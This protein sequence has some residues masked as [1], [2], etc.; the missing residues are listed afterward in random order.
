MVDS[1][2]KKAFSLGQGPQG[3][4]QMKVLVL[5]GNGMLGHVVVKHFADKGHD[6]TFTVREK[7]PEW[8]PLSSPVGVVKFDAKLNLPKLA[9][10]DWV[11]NC[12][13]NIKQKKTETVDFYHINSVFPWRLALACK[14]AGPKLIHISSDCVFSGKLPMGEKYHPLASKDATDEYGISKALG[15]PADAIVI[16]TSIIGPSDKPEGLYEWYR[17]TKKVSVPGFDNHIWSGVTTLFLA[18]FIESLITNNEINIPDEGG[19]IQLASEP[20]T[21]YS[22]LSIIKDVFKDVFSP[23]DVVH[24]EIMDPVNRALMNSTKIAPEIHAQLVELRDWMKEHN[25]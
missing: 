1:V 7:V 19:L 3:N 15:E 17:R 12:I 10:F 9:G 18:Q 11:I 8:M 20:I 22:L 2:H 6:V 5:G 14:K 13:G 23:V 24:S 25:E 4:A 16:R 21:K